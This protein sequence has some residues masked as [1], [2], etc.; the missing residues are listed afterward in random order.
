MITDFINYLI[1][2]GLSLSVLYIFYYFFLSKESMYRFNRL[3]LLLSLLFSFITPLFTYPGFISVSFFAN[4]I[5]LTQFQDNYYQIKTLSMQT[6]GSINFQLLLFVVYL[7]VAVI[8]LMR[9]SLNLLRFRK[10]NRNYPYVEVKGYRIRLVDKQILPHSFFSTVYINKKEYS[11]GQIPPELLDHEFIHIS[12]VHSLDI[13]IIELLKVFF[14]FNPLLIYYKNAMLLNHEYLADHQFSVSKSRFNAYKEILLNTAFRNTKTYLA[15][16]FNYSFTKKRLLMMT[17]STFSRAAIIKMVVVIPLFLV[18]GLFV[19]NAQETS[20]RVVTHTEPPPPP[21]PFG[22][23]TWWSPVLKEHKIN[24]DPSKSFYSQNL[25]ET[26]DML[27][28]ENGF[29]KLKGHVFITVRATD[30]AYN[31]IS[32]ESAEYNR[33]DKSIEAIDGF[34]ETYKQDGDKS[35]LISE[36]K[37]TKST[38]ALVDDDKMAPPPPPPPPPPKN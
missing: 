34:V 2:S 13:L 38:F 15:S 5:N 24:P 33:A 1:R 27:V 21:P 31:V 28:S 10:I 20:R 12:Q 22:H 6:G 8:L 29:I 18:L 23:N 37:F 11:E 7:V 32:C 26:A 19:T 4:A 25:F 3:F 9:F 30:K 35:I 14:W 17:K 36:K 16:S